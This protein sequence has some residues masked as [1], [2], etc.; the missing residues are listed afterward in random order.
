MKK[1]FEQRLCEAL[2]VRMT[3]ALKDAFADNETHALTSSHA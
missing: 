2:K 1:N 3:K